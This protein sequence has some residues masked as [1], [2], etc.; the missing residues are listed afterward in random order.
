MGA[1]SCCAFVLRLL[2]V[3]AGFVCVL[4]CLR[5]VLA[6]LAVLAGLAVLAV[7]CLLCLSWLCGGT[8]GLDAGRPSGCHSGGLSGS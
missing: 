7:L 2:V 4:A 1:F 3:L 8:P 5:A 6:V